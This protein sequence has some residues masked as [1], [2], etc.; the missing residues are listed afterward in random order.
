MATAA[1]KNPSLEFLDH[2]DIVASSDGDTFLS[3]NEARKLALNSDY[4]VWFVREGEDDGDYWVETLG[5]E[6]CDSN[7]EE[8]HKRWR[9]SMFEKH[10]PAPYSVELYKQQFVNKMGFFVSTKPCSRKH[11]NTVFTY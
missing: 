4:R 3:L 1:T 7:D 5:E 9:E 6:P 11:E 2:Y 10:G 8:I